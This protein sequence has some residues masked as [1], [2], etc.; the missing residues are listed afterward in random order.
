[1]ELFDYE[2]LMG[3]AEKTHSQYLS[4]SPFPHAVFD[5]FA[6]LEALKRAVQEFPTLE[7]VAWYKYDN[8]LER[9]LAMPHV[10]LLPTSLRMFFLEFNSGRFVQFLEKLTGISGLIPDPKFNG[11]GLHLILPGGKLDI[12]AD[13]NFH[14]ETKL[15]RRL[16]VLL[17][18]NENWKETYGGHL[19]LW[20]S[21]MTKAEKKI[22]PLFNRMAVF[23]TSDGSLHGHP[24]PLNCPEGS[25]RKSMAVY[26]Y[27]NGRPEAELSAP[28]STMFKKRPQDP[29]SQ[30]LD[31]LRKKRGTRRV[32][33]LKTDKS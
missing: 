25:S 22:L 18:L 19:E 4:A 1:M 26:Y 10:D 12:H 15:D 32:A 31:E 24:E 30:E 28:H 3:L 5:D 17:Y 29:E 16:N 2:K 33:D 13:Y 14:P 20:D 23:S 9:K 6:N 27:T 11:G 21:M 8:P 7:K